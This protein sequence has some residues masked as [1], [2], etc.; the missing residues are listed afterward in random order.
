MAGPPALDEE[1]LS[2][3]D[4]NSEEEGDDYETGGDEG[5][6]NVGLGGLDMSDMKK[7]GGEEENQVMSQRGNR[8]KRSREEYLSGEAETE[9]E[10]DFSSP[11]AKVVTPSKEACGDQGPRVLNGA[12]V[13]RNKRRIFRLG[14]KG[15]RVPCDKPDC[16]STFA[17]LS[18]LYRHIKLVH[19]KVKRFMS[20]YG[21]ASSM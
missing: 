3:G 2:S 21:E 5:E 16:T 4:E 17:H 18:G 12:Q 7:K 13:K 1:E 14:D 10:E 20:K 15:K 19:E 11:P 9:E 6:V 8:G